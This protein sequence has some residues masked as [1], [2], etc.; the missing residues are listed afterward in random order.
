MKFDDWIATI[1][2]ESCGGLGWKQV[3]PA[4]KSVFPWTEYIIEIDDWKMYSPDIK[5]WCQQNLIG[6]YD[7]NVVSYFE[8]EEDSIMF[9]L[10]YA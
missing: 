4:V 8:L 1:E 10:R 7:I 9:A 6:Q 5:L 3:G 2:T